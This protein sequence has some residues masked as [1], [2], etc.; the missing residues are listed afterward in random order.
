MTVEVAEAAQRWVQHAQVHTKM[1]VSAFATELPLDALAEPL[2][3]LPGDKRRTHH[4]S[5]TRVVTYAHVVPEE[6]NRLRHG[7]DERLLFRKVQVH[8][9]SLEERGQIG[10]LQACGLFGPPQW[11][12]PRRSAHQDEEVIRKSNGEEDDPTAIAVSASRLT[13][14]FHNPLVLRAQR[15]NATRPHVPL[16]SLLNNAK[17]DIRQQRRE[18]ST[19][20]RSGIR[21]EELIFRKHTGLQEC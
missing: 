7:S 8:S 4:P 12:G 15:W 10:F 20:G 5:M 18:D 19:L 2:G 11:L 21:S 3:S 9:L 13:G 1:E 14:A 6:A 16:I 17:S